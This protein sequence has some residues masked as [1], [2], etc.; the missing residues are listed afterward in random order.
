MTS[1]YYKRSKSEDALSGLD[2][3]ESNSN[4]GKRRGSGSSAF[5]VKQPS[6]GNL[7]SQSRER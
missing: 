7:A 2:Q 5:H 6:N 3:P 1:F 4:G